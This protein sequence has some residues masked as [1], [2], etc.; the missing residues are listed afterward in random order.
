MLLRIKNGNL[1]ALL[2]NSRNKPVHFAIGFIIR[3]LRELHGLSQCDLARHSEANLS[4][5]N[6]IEGG[7]NNISIR[8][9]HL[10]CN[11]LHLS[12]ADLTSI[13]CNVERSVDLSSRLANR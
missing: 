4:Y 12:P 3:R 13:L 10:L 9:I 7:L 11:A 2:A 8:K 1:Q 5:I 6:S